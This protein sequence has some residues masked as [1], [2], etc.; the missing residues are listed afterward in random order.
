M[1][2][3]LLNQMY[4]EKTVEVQ[5]LH[6]EVA[7]LT[8]QISATHDEK[9][10]TDS[11]A[12]I[13]VSHLRADKAVLESALQEVQGKLKLSESNL[14]TLQMESQTKI[15]Q[16]KS[17]LAAARQNQE[18]LM[19]DHEKLL[20]LLE[21]VKPNEEKFRGT[22][23]GLELKLK[24]SEY[25][26][27]QL[28]EEIS[29]LKVQLERTAQLQDEV[30][31]LKKSLNEAKFENERLEAS[32]QILSGDYEELK[33]ERISFM[34]KISISQQVVSEL[35][36]CK[37]KKVALQE[38][39]LRLEGDLTAIEA[40]GSQEAAL[41]NE[42]AQI[43]RENSQF[44]RRIKCLEK[45]K[46][47]CLSRAQAIEEELKQNKEVKQEGCESVATLPYSDSNVTT[48]SFHDKSHPA[49]MEQKQN[50][51]QLNE[52]PSM[53]TSQETSCAHQNQRQVDDE[54][55]YN[56]GRSQDIETDLLSKIQ[57]LENELAD[58]LE[59]N[60]MYKSQLKSL[61]SKELSSPSDTS[62]KKDG[63]DRKVSS[64]EAELKDL[65]ERYLQMSLKYAEVEAQK[66]Q[67]VMK[68]KSVN[69]GRKWFS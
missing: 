53:G 60:D 51:L 5:N 24:A 10:G 25:E 29:S 12:V 19:A 41:K 17:E 20:N 37:R 62:M 35:E 30:L 16:L 54:Q 26:K 43:K 57:S 58:A 18:V 28:T 4:M 46:E 2:E 31:S 67:L 23:R 39:V 65:Q 1:E 33:T 68:L 32:F 15:Q 61:L 9:G 36:D 11:E 6:R 50:N 56:L 48:T 7:H 66:E 38:K 59:A 52:K 21:D 69:S 42:L 34:Q 40:L 14:G 8:E 13:E 63:Y 47:D 55:H 27:L 22:I 44:Q 45:E 64:L 3:S 49:M